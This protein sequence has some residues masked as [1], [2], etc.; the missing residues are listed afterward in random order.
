MEKNMNTP[1]RLKQ[2][3]RNNEKYKDLELAFSKCDFTAV[4]RRSRHKS[5]DMLIVYDENSFNNQE[6]I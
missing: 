5:L 1:K 2:T 3:N 4:R 6:S